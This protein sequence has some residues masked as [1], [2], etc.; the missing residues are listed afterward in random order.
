MGTGFG[1]LLWSSVERTPNSGRG[2]TVQNFWPPPSAS[3]ARGAWKTALQCQYEKGR[4]HNIAFSV[5][6]CI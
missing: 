3:D 1:V 4:V 5:I 2:T 6:C